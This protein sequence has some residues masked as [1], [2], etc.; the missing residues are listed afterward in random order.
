MSESYKPM[1]N[2][3]TRV[4]LRLIDDP[5][6]YD[7][8]AEADPLTA[9][10]VRAFGARLAGRAE[11]VA[12]IMDVLAE[13]GFTFTFAK[14]RILADSSEMEAQEA[15]RYLLSSGFEDTEF[16][17]FLEYARKWGVL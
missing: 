9:D 8:V 4:I 12:A 14:D 13:R 5:V 15:K 6:P 3:I 2:H 7:L 16:Q 17:V 10:S 11:R 1:V